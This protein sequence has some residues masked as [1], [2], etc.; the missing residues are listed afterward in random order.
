MLLSAKKFV[1]KNDAEH[2]GAIAGQ[3][4]A[5]VLILVLMCV[6]YFDMSKYSDVES[7]LISVFA[8]SICAFIGLRTTCS[9]YMG[10]RWDIYQLQRDKLQESGMTAVQAFEKVRDS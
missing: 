6:I 7:I 1:H 5:V 3:A 2:A 9:R 8:F 10:H 4:Y